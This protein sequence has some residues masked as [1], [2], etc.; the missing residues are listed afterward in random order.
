[1]KDKSWSNRK[2]TKTI[3]VIFEWSWK[4]KK[5]NDRWIQ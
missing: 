3:I 4:K 5:F 1:M 2:K